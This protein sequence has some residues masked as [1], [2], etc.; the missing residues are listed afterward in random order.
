VERVPTQLKDS[1]LDTMEIV[2]RDFQ[3]PAGAKNRRAPVQQYSYLW[4]SPTPQDVD[5]YI[6]LA[7]RAGFRMLLF[8]YTASPRAPG[9]SGSTS[10]FL[11]ALLT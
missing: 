5:R 9:T 2:E 4:C 6:A 1:F 7:Q 8:S 3:M 11:A 10:C